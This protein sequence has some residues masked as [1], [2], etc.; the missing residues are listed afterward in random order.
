MIEDAPNGKRYAL[1][2][3]LRPDMLPARYLEEKKTVDDFHEANPTVI[4][5][6]DIN[7]KRWRSFDAEAV[8]YAQDVNENY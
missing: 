1:R 5:A 7:A 6:W 2:F 8:I 4:A 3:T